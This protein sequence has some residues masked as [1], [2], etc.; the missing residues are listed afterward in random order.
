[1]VTCHLGPA[2]LY[3]MPLIQDAVN[4]L[5]VSKMKASKSLVVML[6]MPTIG[7]LE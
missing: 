3:F 4:R 2:S 5:L 7:T 6:S 1:M